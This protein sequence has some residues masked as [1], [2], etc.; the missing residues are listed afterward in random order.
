VFAGIGKQSPY[1]RAAGTIFCMAVTVRYSWWRLLHSIPTDQTFIQKIWIYGFLCVEMC[2]I[3]STLLVYFFLSRTVSRSEAADASQASPLLSE[4]TDIFI[5]TYDESRD[6]IER[7]IVGALAV[8]HPDLRIWLLDDGDRAWARE[9]ARSLG[10]QYV[11]RRNGKHAKA[12]NVNNGVAIAL[13]TGRLPKFM[14]LLDADFVPH[15]SIL[16]RTLG[17]FADPRIGI[18]QTPQ[19]FFNPDPVQS[20]L[21]C[22]TVWPDEQRFFFNVVLPCKDAWNAA[23]C[24][25]TSAV[26]RIDAFVA[27]GGMAVNTVTEDMLTSFCF[28]EHGYRTIHLNERLS[29]G[30]APESLAGFIRQRSRWCLGAIQQLFTRWSFLGSAR[31][32]FI[33]RLSFFDTVVYW[34]FQALFKILIALTP[35]VYWFTGTA[36]ISATPTDMLLWLVPVLAANLIFM[37]YIAENTILPGITDVTQLLTAFAVCRTVAT[38]LVRPFGRP[39]KV[40]AKGL[41][42]GGWTVEWNLMAPFLVLAALNVLGVL[43]HSSRFSPAHG[44]AGYTL[45]VLWSLINAAILL[46][47][48]LACIEPPRRRRDERFSTSEKV[49]IRL[50]PMGGDPI[51]LPGELKDI[52]LGGAAIKEI[53]ETHTGWRN[54]AGPSE[55]VLYS[56]ADAKDLVLPFRVV[57]RRGEILSIQ[58]HEETWIRHALIRKL[59]TGDYHQDVERIDAGAVVMTLARDL[60]F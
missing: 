25:G 20:N 43:L 11:A 58:F 54:V 36:V 34:M 60:I 26:F 3:L 38:A 28:R 50:L 39:F 55:L 1:A 47:A 59:F 40:T 41:V 57:D 45:A 17:L 51:E 14:L 22:S 33:N 27:S 56:K 4:P 35:A 32:S 19:H 29:L 21:V 53:G 7:T 10:I 42:T 23:F 18:V 12:G 37:H 52:S 24:C 9:L 48:A 13:K 8:E 15:R 2:V 44:Q 30:L 46:L 49:T 16:K 6:I 31:I 5:A